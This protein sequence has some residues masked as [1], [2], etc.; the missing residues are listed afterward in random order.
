MIQ[1]INRRA[2]WTMAGRE[3]S[4][5]QPCRT[6]NR[7]AHLHKRLNAGSYLTHVVLRKIRHDLQEGEFVSVL[8]VFANLE[9]LHVVGMTSL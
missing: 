6:G 8:D 2:E 1:V 3:N 9:G 5:S 7:P 4:S